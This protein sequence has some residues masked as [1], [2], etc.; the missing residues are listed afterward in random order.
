MDLEKNSSF[1][2]LVFRQKYIRRWGLMHSFIP[3]NLAEHSSECAIIAHALA[4][5]GNRLFGKSYDVGK[6]VTMALFHDVPEVFTGDMPTPVKYA[7]P[8]IRNEFAVIEE[9]SVKSLMNKLPNELRDVYEPLFDETEDK[10]LHSLVKSA[11]RL[12]AYIKCTEEEKLN[13]TEFSRARTGIEERLKETDSPEL[14]YFMEHFL[15]AFGVTLDE[16]QEG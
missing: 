10:E 5:I 8:V 3:E 11:D 13:N 2:A 9:Q 16:Q 1:F 4:E 7:N 15:P 14:R 12:C 6:V